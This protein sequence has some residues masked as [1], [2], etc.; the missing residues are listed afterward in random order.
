MKYNVL[1]T[2]SLTSAIDDFFNNN[3]SCMKCITTSQRYDD[4]V[5]HIKGFKPDLFIVCLAGE[6]KA[7]LSTMQNIKIECVKNNTK[8]VIMG[9]QSDCD[10]FSKVTTDVADL[11]LVRPITITAINHAIDDMMEAARKAEE[12]ARKAKEAE[13]KASMPEEKKHILVID[14]DASMLRT[15]KG[16]LEDSYNVAT[17]LGG[18]IAMRFLQKKT[19]DLILLDY[20]MPNISGPAVL[21]ELRKDKRTKDIPVVFLTGVSDVERIKKVLSMKPQGYLLKPVDRDKLLDIIVK[22]IG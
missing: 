21:E 15:I 6:S 11:V 5:R 22:V 7:F 20:E 8:L 13:L 16:Q 14:D 17:A 18:N 1:L 4:M 2:G 9:E 10:E 19:T 3:D 12:E